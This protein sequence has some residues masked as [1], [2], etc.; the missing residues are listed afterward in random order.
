[1]P[2]ASPSWPRR[3]TTGPESKHGRRAGKPVGLP[4]FQA[5]HRDRGRVRFTTGA[6]RLKRDRRHLTLPVIG[7]LRGKENTRRLERLLAK[8]RAR[9]LSMTLSEQGGGRLFVSVAT[10]IAH[11]PPMAAALTQC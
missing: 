3:C 9:V 8:G 10:I 5:R 1:M 11:S 6:M 7:R 4:R 2:A